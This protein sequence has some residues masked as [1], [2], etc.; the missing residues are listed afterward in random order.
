M[1]FDPGVGVGAYSPALVG[2][3]DTGRLARELGIVVSTD[4]PPC[5]SGDARK[6]STAVLSPAIIGPA[7]SY[8]SASIGFI[9]AAFR[10]G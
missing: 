10:A 1:A 8:R 3:D 4:S 2:V 9:R 5:A 7:Y 6:S